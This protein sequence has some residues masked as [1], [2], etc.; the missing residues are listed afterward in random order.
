M[1]RRLFIALTLPEAVIS[2]VDREL[3]TVR[4]RYGESAIR[5]EPKEKWHMTLLFLGA[6]DDGMIA[7]VRE[8]MEAALDG[9]DWQPLITEDITYAPPHHP[10]MIWLTLSKRSSEY[11]GKLRERL[12]A[13]LKARGVAWRDDVQTFRGHITLA[14]LPEAPAEALGALRVAHANHCN[15]YAFELWES[16]QSTAGSQYSS[17]VRLAREEKI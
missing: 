3:D 5:F 13:E 14:R 10:R 9:F 1:K 6:Q 11:F 15:E 16:K 7:N 4:S 17:L 2:M 12:A 8:A